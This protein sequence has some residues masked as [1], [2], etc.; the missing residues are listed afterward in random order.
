MGYDLNTIQSEY[1]SDLDER[2]ETLKREGFVKLPSIEFFDLEEVACRITGEMTN[3][4]FKELGKHHASFLKLLGTEEN[5]APKLYEYAVK[6]FRYGGS[7]LDAYHIARRVEPGNSREMYR[8]HFDSHLFTL[9]LPIQIP[10]AP[11]G[12]TAGELIY[13]PDSRA[14]PTSEWSNFVGK[15]SFK[16]FAS[17]RGIEAFSKKSTRRE[18]NFL[19]YSPMLFLGR[20][21]LHTNKA[22]SK[23][24]SKY[25][26]TLLAH[27]F[28]PSP[29]I[30]LGAFL[31]RVRRR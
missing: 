14:H 15:A 1:W 21:T 13:F 3:V 12:A 24:C 2:L 8:A 4:T 19:D 9:V 29:R 11:Q 23:H 30:G 31:R 26:L 17:K 25:R 5:L 16:R 28:D 27:Y 7:A 18:E 10:T 6:E 20:T 22:V